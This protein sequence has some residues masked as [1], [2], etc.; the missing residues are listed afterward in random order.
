[1]PGL[2]VH[3]VLCNLWLDVLLFLW[4]VSCEHGFSWFY[5][6]LHPLTNVP[7]H[8]RQQ[9]VWQLYQTIQ[10]LRNN[11]IIIYFTCSFDNQSSTRQQSS[12][13]W[14][15]SHLSVSKKIFWIHTI[16]CNYD[17]WNCSCLY[18]NSNYLRVVFPLLGEPMTAILIGIIGFGEFWFKNMNGACM[19]LSF[20]S[21][22]DR[23]YMWRRNITG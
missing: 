9:N 21:S 14:S 23:K 7:N 16:N 6:V 10:I 4:R 22:F 8:I 1:M 5:V 11:L 19:N 20:A 3:L 12:S 17:I 13:L 15:Y 18:I 2:P